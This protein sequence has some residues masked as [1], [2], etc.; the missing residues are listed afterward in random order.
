[1]DGNDC[2]SVLHIEL[3]LFVVQ[4]SHNKSALS[5]QAGHGNYSYFCTLFPINPPRLHF[6]LQ[7]PRLVEIHRTYWD[8]KLNTQSHHH[9]I[10]PFF[11]FPFLS[12]PFHHPFQTTFDSPNN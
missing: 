11:L 9:P 3:P 8:S 1:L 4:I 6:L 2:F 5:P 7:I 10:S 12:L